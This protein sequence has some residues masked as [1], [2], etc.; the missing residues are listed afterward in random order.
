MGAIR[1][2]LMITVNQESFE[3]MA[4]VLTQLAKTLAAHEAT[5]A[6]SLSTIRITMEEI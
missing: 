2:D 6:E 3:R 1:F 5:P 4:E